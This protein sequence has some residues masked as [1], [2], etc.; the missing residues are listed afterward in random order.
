MK[1]IIRQDHHR[2]QPQPSQRIDAIDQ[3]MVALPLGEIDQKPR[4]TRN[5]MT[6]VFSH[7]VSLTFERFRTRT[8]ALRSSAHPAQSF[9][10]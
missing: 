10:A 7:E 5:M 2:F 6:P 3:Q 8:I 4:C 1:R 9:T